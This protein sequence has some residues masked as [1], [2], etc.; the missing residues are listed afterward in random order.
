MPS[1]NAGHIRRLDHVRYTAQQAGLLLALLCRLAE[2]SVLVVDELEKLCVAEFLLRLVEVV[3]EEL[4][5]HDLHLLLPCVWGGV[6]TRFKMQG[7][8]SFRP[9]VLRP[10]FSL[11]PC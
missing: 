1:D 7:L 2:D 5:R 4:I 10:S 6:G 3:L 8:E 9:L 11:C